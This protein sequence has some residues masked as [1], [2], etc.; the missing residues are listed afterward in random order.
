MASQS[1]DAVLD[2]AYLRLSSRRSTWG[3]RMWDTAACHVGAHDWSYWE[4]LDPVQPWQRVRTCARC[5]R[6]QKS[7]DH[8]WGAL[9]CL[10]GLHYWSEW[11]VS[12]VQQPG[13]QVRTCARCPQTKTNAGPVPLRSLFW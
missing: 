8:S 7:D 13:A 6:A 3:D 11:Q 9:A 10:V 2:P 5:L 1:D 12:D 4:V